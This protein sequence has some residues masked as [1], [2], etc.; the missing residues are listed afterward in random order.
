[1]L[2]RTHS[3]D[4]SSHGDLMQLLLS[5]QS[6]AAVLDAPSLYDL[7]VSLLLLLLG[8]PS[9]TNN[10]NSVV[11]RRILCRVF[12]STRRAHVKSQSLTL[13]GP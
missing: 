6:T 5:E 9:A 7:H 1:M 13:C 12:T 11:K 4:D 2:S 10:T 8:R 3:P